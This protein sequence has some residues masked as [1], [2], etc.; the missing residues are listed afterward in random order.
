DG[1]DGRRMIRFN[2]PDNGGHLAYPSPG[3]Q[4]LADGYSVFVVF[5]LNEPLGNGNPFPRLWRGAD[6]SHAFF[7]RR[8]TAEV[9]I[10]ANP[11][12]VAA[13]PSHPFADGFETGDFAILTARLTPSSQQLY[14]NGIM[15]DGSDSPIASYTIDNSL[16]QIGNSVRGDIGDVLV[17]D[18]SASLADL[19]ETGQALAK[20]YGT[21]WQS[22]LDPGLR[23]PPVELVTAHR[24]NSSQAPENTLVA[25]TAAVGFAGMTE[26][27]AQLAAD[28]V[29]VLMHDATVDRTTNGSG[30]VDE[31]SYQG[32]MELLDAGSWFSPEFAGEPIPT[33]AE[34][35]TDALDLGLVPVIE[36]KLAGPG[37]AAAYYAELESLDVLDKILLDCFN[38][39]FIA[40]FRALSPQTRLGALGSGQLTQATLDTIK[41]TGADYVHW[42]HGSITAQTVDL[43]HANG[44]KLIVYTV[45]SESRMIE[46][47]DMGVDSITTDYP[48]VLAALLPTSVE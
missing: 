31:T 4:K 43:V 8:S 7:L 5:R 38:W 12:A 35:I 27:D 9:E 3:A 42:A 45:N 16:F 48:A 40:N 17:Y 20:A 29:I 6:D 22:I 39:D 36:A 14:F 26:F 19:D 30:R 47:L 2:S 25:I 11:L 33:M 24:G 32:G 46:L 34:A 23:S 28:G 37:D 18:H 41:N 44:L 1:V 13:R 15:V 10:K 21:T